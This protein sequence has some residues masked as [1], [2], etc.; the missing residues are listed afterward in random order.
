TW[1]GQAGP[2][3]RSAGLIFIRS[4]ERGERV[5]LA[6]ASRGYSGQMPAT[7]GDEATAGQWTAGLLVAAFAWVVAG[8][9]WWLR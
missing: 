6:M 8:S 5:Y 4:Y 7:P 2:Y 9:A 3:A 1:I